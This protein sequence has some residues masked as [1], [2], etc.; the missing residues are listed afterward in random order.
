MTLDYWDSLGFDC[1]QPDDEGLVSLVL[2]T[3]YRNLVEHRPWLWVY[4]LIGRYG[5]PVAINYILTCPSCQQQHVDK[6]E[7][8]FRSHRTH[9]CEFCGVTWRPHDIYTCGVAT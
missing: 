3:H 9:L 1:P 7:W 4:D 2:A 6:G 5:E 8:A